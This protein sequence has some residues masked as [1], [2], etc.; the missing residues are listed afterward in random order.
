MQIE[1]EI[2]VHAA[3]D[4]VWQ[5]YCRVE[6]WPSWAPAVTNV[7]WP[8]GATWAEGTDFQVKR[9][10]ALGFDVS[11]DATIQMS[12]PGS[13]TVWEGRA[14]ALIVVSSFQVTD[15]LGGSN[16]QLQMTYHGPGALFLLLLR[17]PLTS[18]I[19]TALSRFKTYVE[20]K[21]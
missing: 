11:F 13:V 17:A 18:Q 16:A 21:S 3:R 9:R 8:L 12:V 20:R 7:T 6:A 19:S 1:R 4:A 5:K 10:I 15:S 14:P 2:Y